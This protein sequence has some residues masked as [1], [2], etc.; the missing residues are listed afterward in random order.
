LNTWDSLGGEPPP[1]GTT[2][3]YHFAIN[4]SMRGDL[5]VAVQRLLDWPWPIRHG[6]DHGTHEAVY[7]YDPDSNG[8]ELA[9]DRDPSEWPYEDGHIVFSR[10][11]LDISSLVS[12]RRSHTR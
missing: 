6:T 3:L 8:I 9:W 11:P 1:V 12:E 5:A 4:Y 2:G 7:L 10:K